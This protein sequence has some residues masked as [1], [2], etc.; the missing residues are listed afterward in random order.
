VGVTQYLKARLLTCQ[1]LDP[2]GPIGGVGGRQR[3]LGHQ[4]GLGFGGNVALVAVALVGA[5]LAGVAGLGVDGGEHPILGDLA[6]DPPGA[7]PI[8]LFDVLAGHQRQQRDRLGLLSLQLKVGD[9]RKHRQ[10]VVDQPRHQRLPGLRVIPSTHRL[11]RPVIVVGVNGDLTCLGDQP[12]DPADRRDQLGD[13]VLGGD[14]I[15]Q[16]GGVQHPPA[17]PLEH[18][19]RLDNPTDSVEDPPGLR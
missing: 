10:R 6:G 19:G 1:Q 11:A 2:G 13:G 18:P 9:R 17:P 12:P 7:W 4:P 16:D 8:T 3:T 5:G 14:R 15:G